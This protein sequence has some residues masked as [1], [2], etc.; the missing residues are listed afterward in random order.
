MELAV[1]LSKYS[2]EPE[3]LGY[4]EEFVK[5]Y[6]QTAYLTPDEI[7]AV[8]DL[9]VLRILSNVSS[10]W[11]IIIKEDIFALPRKINLIRFVSFSFVISFCFYIF[12][13]CILCWSD[14]N[15]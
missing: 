12:E 8:P 1:C 5:G 10:N 7:D 9:M 13:G 3:P 4:F 2:G 6:A 11:L 14:I 15:R